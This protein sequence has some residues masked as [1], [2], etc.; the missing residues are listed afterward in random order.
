MNPESICSLHLILLA[1][2]V[3]FVVL[4]FLLALTPS[5]QCQQN[6]ED[7]LDNGT[8]LAGQAKYNE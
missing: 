1:M 2:R 7:W 8:A 3:I 5:L 6:A 4:T